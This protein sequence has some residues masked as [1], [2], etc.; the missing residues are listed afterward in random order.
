MYR[1]EP[2]G[3]KDELLL[4]EQPLLS[5]LNLGQELGYLLS[6][7]PEDLD[8]PAAGREVTV[9]VCDVQDLVFEVELKLLLEEAT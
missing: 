6:Q 8:C 7:P 5:V 4:L 2:T 3:L 1:N 9:D